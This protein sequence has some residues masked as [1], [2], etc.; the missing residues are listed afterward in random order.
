MRPRFLVKCIKFIKQSKISSTHLCMYHVWIKMN[1]NFSYLIFNTKCNVESRNA[2]QNSYKLHLIIIS[3]RSISVE[4][5]YNLWGACFQI[6]PVK[7]YPKLNLI[8]DQWPQS[9]LHGKW[10]GKLCSI[11]TVLPCVTYFKSDWRSH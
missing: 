11:A 1:W 8:S 5:F 7:P 10:D 4:V 2:L 6:H 3:F 9:V